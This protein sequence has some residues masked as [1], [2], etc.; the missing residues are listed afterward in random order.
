MISL[1]YLSR[2]TDHPRQHYAEDD[3]Y[4]LFLSAAKESL[5]WYMLYMAQLAYLCRMRISEATDFR[6]S[7]DPEKG[8]LIRRRKG[9][10]DNIVAWAPKSKHMMLH[11]LSLMKLG[12]KA[13][14]G[15]YK[16]YL[17]HQGQNNGC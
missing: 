7:D 5:Y 3:D 6:D 4:N 12:N 8:L 9:S 10:K 16:Q 13:Y 17:S 11:N 14:S 2:L 1:L 15:N